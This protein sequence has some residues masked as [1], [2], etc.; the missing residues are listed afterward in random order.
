[1]LNCSVHTFLD[2]IMMGPFQ[3]CCLNLEFLVLVFIF[4]GIHPCSCRCHVPC[5]LLG[6]IVCCSSFSV[7]APFWPLWEVLFLWWILASTLHRKCASAFVWTS[8][9]GESLSQTRI[10]CVFQ[11]VF[12]F[13]IYKHTRSF[14][15]YSDT[16]RAACSKKGIPLLSMPYQHFFSDALMWLL[17]SEHPNRSLYSSCNLLYGQL[18]EPHRVIHIFYVVVICDFRKV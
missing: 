8:F 14:S 17:C 10:L 6:N 1:M 18:K 16:F 15:L 3:F 13:L 5:I 11:T 4:Y 2:H 12:A 9:A 7:G